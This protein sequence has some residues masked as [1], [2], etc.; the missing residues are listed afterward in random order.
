MRESPAHAMPADV[1]LERL[2]GKRGTVSL[3][4]FFFFFFFPFSCCVLLALEYFGIFICS[5]FFSVPRLSFSLFFFFRIFCFVCLHFL[6]FTTFSIY[7]FVVV[8]FS[9]LSIVYV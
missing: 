4:A 9:V 1:L 2:L 7:S 6:V 5:L 3:Y 8:V